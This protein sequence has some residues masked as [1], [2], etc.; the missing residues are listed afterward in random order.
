M[1]FANHWYIIIQI[2][3]EKE[4]EPDKKIARL[5]IGVEGGFNPDVGAKKYE[6]STAL[7]IV[8]FPSQQVINL[9]HN[10]LPELVS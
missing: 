7:S 4:T 3:A 8:V 5:A 9:P 6:Y 10:D 1:C 2:P